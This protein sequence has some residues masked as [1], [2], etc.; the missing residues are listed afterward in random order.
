MEIMKC[1][2]CSQKKAKRLCPAKSAQICPQCCGEKRILEI[3]CP[4][5]CQYLESGRRRELELHARHYTSP[6]PIRQQKHHRILSQFA[7]FISGLEYLLGDERHGSRDFTDQ[8]AAAA[9][10][11]VIETLRTEQ[12]GVLYERTSNDVRVDIVR[13][14]IA[15][16][17][18]SQRSRQGAAD[19]PGRIVQSA[20]TEGMKLNDVVECLETIR[21][22][23]QSHLREGTG[24]QGY[25]DFLARLLPRRPIVDSG[26][27]SL[28][29]PGR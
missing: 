24:S 29:I 7:D 3:D 28:I 26:G 9:L 10:D 20:E 19:V 21:E 23:V 4:D 13:R 12:K 16:F 25:V 8:D 15:E 6:D 11:L 18:Q 27:P 17:V 22:V 1:P 5:D 14:R 2:V